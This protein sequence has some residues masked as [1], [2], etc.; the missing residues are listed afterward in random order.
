M[1]D[2]CEHGG[3]L[4]KGEERPDVI[5]HLPGLCTLYRDGSFQ[6]LT[7][8]DL[9]ACADFQDGVAS[10]DIFI[11]SS[12]GIW[13]RIFLPLSATQGLKAPLVLHFHGGGFCFGSPSS[14]HVHNYCT[15]MALKSGSIWV[16]VHYRLA[17]EH[18]LPVAYEDAYVALLWLR[19]QGGGVDWS[20]EV[21]FT[22]ANGKACSEHGEKD[23]WLTQYADFSSC[24]FAGDSSGGTI[25]HYLTVQAAGKDWSPLNIKGILL[26]HPAFPQEEPQGADDL[27][28]ARVRFYH[29]SSLPPGAPFGHVLMN[30]LHRDSPVKLSQIAL[31][32]LF[33][34]I[35]EKDPLRPGDL[36]YFHALL[37]AGHKAQLFESHGVGHC[38]Y[39]HLD[40]ERSAAAAAEMLENA[41]VGFIQ[42][43][44]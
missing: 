36:A 38:F 17:P 30:P 3:E 16:S 37:D 35:A 33:V 41:V 21:E 10:H 27:T 12:S 26:M 7:D 9:P 13:A 23:P 20:G 42:K 4:L 43:L 25:V 2:T 32:P 18:P 34:A 29:K 28:Q 39:T 31:P 8:L 14:P 22:K 11:D 44:C 5:D 40:L 1:A 19:A 15:R 6:R 24:F